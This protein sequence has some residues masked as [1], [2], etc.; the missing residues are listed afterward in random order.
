MN[1]LSGFIIFIHVAKARSFATAARQLGL[2]PSSVSKS[3]SRLEE[4]L[5]V[6]LLQRSTRSV[7]L[8]T[9]GTLFLERC[10][11]I[12]DEIS[13]A[14]NELLSSISAPQGRLR[15]SLPLLSNLMLPVLSAFA[16]CYPQIELEL[17]FSDRLVDV[18]DEGFDAVVRTGELNDSRLMNKRIGSSRFVYVGAPSYFA[19]HGKPAHPG[20]LLHHAC[21][22]HR[23]PTTG[24]LEKWPLCSGRSEIDI[25]LQAKITSNHVET[26]L[27]MAIQGH[28]IACLPD[29]TVKQ[30]LASGTLLTILDKWAGTS[31]T[32]RVLWP[33]NRWVL[34]KVRAFVDFMADN[35]FPKEK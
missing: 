25:H 19:Q 27:H 1:N 22:I 23:F 33:S 28:G 18:I 4:K 24:L 9:E 13:T 35:L 8:T 32:F 12:L 30:A 2:S 10:K 31:S 7:S 26:L 14:E 5:G 21:L 11:R 16:T 15:V 20:E 3:I 29:F 6:R 34:P 17:D